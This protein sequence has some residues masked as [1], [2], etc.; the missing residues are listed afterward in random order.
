MYKILGQILFI[1]DITLIDDY[2]K[3]NSLFKQLN[4]QIL[5]QSAKDIEDIDHKQVM[6]AVMMRLMSIEHFIKYILSV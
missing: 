3:W 5:S 2:G 6:S 1:Q 4:D